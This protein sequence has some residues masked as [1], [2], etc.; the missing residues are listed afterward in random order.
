MRA[1]PFLRIYVGIVWLAYGTS[2]L[3]A[4]WAGGKH[5]F[6]AAVTD[7]ASGAGQPFKG[8]LTTFVVPHQALFANLIAYGETLVGISLLFGLLTKAGALGGAFLSVNYF[9]A[10]DRYATRFGV[11]SLELLLFVVCLY[12][13]LTPSGATLSIDSFILGRSTRRSLPGSGASS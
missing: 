12:L 5:Y 2:K 10:T 13:F 8:L 7:A 9:F 1:L 3:T 11:E 4:D 6:L